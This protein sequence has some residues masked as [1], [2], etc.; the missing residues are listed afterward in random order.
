MSEQNYRMRVPYFIGMD[1]KVVTLADLPPTTH[2]RW[3]RRHKA[4]ILAAVSQGLLSFE[5]A[6]ERYSL[7]LEEYLSW[8]RALGSPLERA[9]PRDKSRH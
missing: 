2:R 8:Q 1:G 6:C 7:T 4:I 9:G 3:L 5:E